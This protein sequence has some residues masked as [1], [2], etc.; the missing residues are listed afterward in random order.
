MVDASGN[1]LVF[2]LCTPR[3]GSSLATVMLQNHSS[4]YAAQEMWF[5]MSLL[6]L[7]AAQRRAYGGGAILERFFGGVLP[8]D[9]FADACRAFAVEAYNGLLRGGEGADI[10]VDKSPRYYYLLE[11]LDTLFPRSKRIW[12]LRNPLDVLASYKKLGASRG[13][14]VDLAG[15]LAGSAFDIKAADLTVGLMRYMRYFAAPDP[16]AY[17][18]RYEELVADP[19]GQLAGVS[20]FFGIAYEEGMERY[21]ERM[22]TAKS[23]LYFSMG[24]GDPNVA[25]HAAPHTNAVGSWKETLTK[26]E[27]ELYVRLLGARTFEALGYGE[28]LAEAERWTGARFER[29]PDEALLALRERQLADATGCRWQPGYAMRSGAAGE[30]KAEAAAD[31]GMRA[32]HIGGIAESTVATN[33]L[34]TNGTAT[35]GTAT[36]GLVTNE[37]ATNGP[38]TNEAV[39]AMGVPAA[40]SAMADEAKHARATDSRVHQLQMTVR[41]LEMRLEAG[42]REQRH[43]RAQLGAMKRKAD[44]LKSAIP[45]GR[46]L[47][48]FASAY[49]AG[50]GKK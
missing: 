17:R 33:G 14:A 22:G 26:Q 9:A 8:E 35:N 34:V 19:R 39:S 31:A 7:K 6:D 43:L 24:V 41:A 3:S 23:E 15:L 16:Y 10:V 48:R 38:A 50:G 49:M 27:A 5:L 37:T 29:E 32:L 13:G 1:N 28:A 47:S 20:E 46:R 36:Y 45:F 2:L 4:V 30:F 11:F 44:W 42:I 21:G 18:L 40:L 25:D 12:L